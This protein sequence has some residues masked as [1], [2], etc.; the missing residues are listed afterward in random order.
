MRTPAWVLASAM[1]ML[2]ACA[3]G[4]QAVRE[5]TGDLPAVPADVMYVRSPEIVK[6]LALSYDSLLADV[7][8][9]RAVQHYGTTK[10]LEDSDKSYGLLYPLLDLT[11]SLD[12]RFNIAYHFGSLFL[13][14]PPPG[15]P[16][17]PDLAIRLLEKGIAAQPAKWEFVQGIGFVHYWWYEDYV[18]AAS[19]FER[20][21][22]V[23]GAPNWMKPLAAVTLAEGGRRDA[24]RVLW[25][26]VA[27]TAEEAWY[28]KEAARRLAQLDALDQVDQL[29]AILAAFERT[30]GAP[31]SSW[32][33]VV[34]AGSLRGIPQDPTGV[35]YRLTN[36]VVDLDS[37]S[38]LLP[39]PKHVRSNR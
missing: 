14:E 5:R 20:A 35:A 2:M 11:T 12:D 34:A 3:V 18:T 4:L 9:I 27:S 28:R 10:R 32:D 7:Y 24:S 8:W 25:Q 15:G 23:P 16:G 31:A 21:A 39:L 6:R 37:T 17:R 30:R 22:A 1:V 19:W 13:A 36:G 33:E 26:Q 38:S 29:T